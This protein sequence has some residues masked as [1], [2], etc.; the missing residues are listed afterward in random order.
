M[1]FMHFATHGQ[2]AALIYFY[3]TARPGAKDFSIF[4][5]GG[6]TDVGKLV[7]KPM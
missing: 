6:L 7:L 3:W 2:L 4:R 1:S 5:C